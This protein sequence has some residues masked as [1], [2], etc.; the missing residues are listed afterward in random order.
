MAASPSEP[1]L[2][3]D[4]VRYSVS[5]T[6]QEPAEIRILRGALILLPEEPPL[7]LGE[8]ALAI[9]LFPKVT[10]RLRRGH[11][12]AD[13]LR[14]AVAILRPPATLP[15]SDRRWWPY[16]ICVLAYLEGR[17]RGDVEQ[18]LA[19]SSSTYSRAKRRA[20]ERI[21]AILPELAAQHT[22]EVLPPHVIQKVRQ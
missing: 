13:T 18:I 1:S 5:T 16:R 21:A 22:R 19:I 17:P 3:I 2:M 7:D 20:L 10:D 8:C 6:P 11:M 12:C 4:F 15:H 14:A 9:R